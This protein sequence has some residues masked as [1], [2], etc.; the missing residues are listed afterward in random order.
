MWNDY[1]LVLKVAEW[2]RSNE[3]DKDNRDLGH[4]VRTLRTPLQRK[5]T[6]LYTR[7]FL[8]KSGPTDA[9]PS[10]VLQFCGH[11]NRFAL[12][13]HLSLLTRTDTFAI[14]WN[15]LPSLPLSGK[16]KSMLWFVATTVFSFLDR[17]W[18]QVAAAGGAR[19]VPDHLYGDQALF[20]RHRHA[21]RPEICAFFSSAGKCVCAV[22]LNETLFLT[23][24][25]LQLSCDSVEDIEVSENGRLIKVLY[26]DGYF[27]LLCYQDGELTVLEWMAAHSGTSVRGSAPV[28]NLGFVNANEAV[29][30]RYGHLFN[31]R[32]PPGRLTPRFRRMILEFE[33]ENNALWQ[34]CYRYIAQS[35]YIELET[36]GHVLAAFLLE[37]SRL[38][39]INQRPHHVLFVE[40][41]ETRQEF[42]TA[43]FRSDVPILGLYKLHKR[44]GLYVA[45]HAFTPDRWCLLTRMDTFGKGECHTE[46][47]P[48]QVSSLLLSLWFVDSHQLFESPFHWLTESVFPFFVIYDLLTSVEDLPVFEMKALLN[49][50][51]EMFT[52]CNRR[53]GLIYVGSVYF[54]HIAKCLKLYAIYSRE[55]TTVLGYINS[56]LG[57]IARHNVKHTAK[58]KCIANKWVYK[59]PYERNVVNGTMFPVAPIVS[60]FA[61]PSIDS[62]LQ[63]NGE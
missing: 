9:L 29:G 57:V 7:K 42:K 55:Q 52:W 28:K 44:F 43:L 6:L 22:V 54:S 37:C 2:L 48:Q 62:V 8:E 41:N 63:L 23:S 14:G 25:F 18:Q 34:R 3:D 5:L 53:N 15:L 24:L 4:F 10:Q 47:L 49:V 45:D 30:T 36:P 59:S 13:Q 31:I 61:S 21:K 11:E 38:S 1:Y 35:R 20:L 12:Q 50:G 16:F 58:C 19:R 33:L 40:M 26:F 17:I 56:T 60:P 27:D 51:T 46:P 32:V 39:C